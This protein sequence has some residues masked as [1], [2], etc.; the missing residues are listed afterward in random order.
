[1]AQANAIWPKG[2]QG[3]LGEGFDWDTD[4]W[5]IALLLDTYVYNAAHVYVSDLAA[6]VWAR[7]TALT[8]K[9]ITDGIADFAL[10]QIIGVAVGATI[11]SYCFYRYNALDS[12]ARLGVFVGTATNLPLVTNNG[13]VS[14]AADPG[15]NKLFKL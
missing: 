7:S 12:A 10:K 1:V 6:Y 8:G 4:D 2:R 13:D 5:R 3:F 15:A 14:I 9:T 11:G